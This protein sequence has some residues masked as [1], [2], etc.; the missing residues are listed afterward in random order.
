M[1]PIEYLWKDRKHRLGQR[2]FGVGTICADFSDKSSPHLNLK[3]V[4]NPREVNDVTAASY[5]EG[6]C[7]RPTA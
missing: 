5:T 2:I 6:A 4:R 7:P 3:N 1:E